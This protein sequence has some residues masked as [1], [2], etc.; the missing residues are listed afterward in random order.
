MSGSSGNSAAP[1]AATAAAAAA[2]ATAALAAALGYA[3]YTA[4]DKTAGET[5]RVQRVGTL[6]SLALEASPSKAGGGHVDT[7]AEALRA[8][9]Q[10]PGNQGA[11]VSVL[12]HG[13]QVLDVLSMSTPRKKR[14][15][16]EEMCARIDELLEADACS[17]ATTEA[18][19][20][21]I[22]SECLCAVQDLKVGE[23]DTS[24]LEILSKALDTVVRC[25]DRV[26]ASTQ[27]LL[28][29]D[30]SQRKRGLAMLSRLARQPLASVSLTEISA[31]E[32]VSGLLKNDSSDEIEVVEQTLALLSLFAFG[33]RNGPEA[34]VS[35]HTQ[36][37]SVLYK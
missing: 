29:K 19:E 18:T 23:A 1:A 10:G 12:E 28:S 17:L 4:G 5:S 25:G 36:P 32:V 33:I 22:L 15:A 26:L 24:C 35:V 31:A 27:Q 14:K 16:I 7:T 34:S 9:L 13:L 2:A 11:V 30:T 8:V 20:L 21:S 3:T 6:S 37:F